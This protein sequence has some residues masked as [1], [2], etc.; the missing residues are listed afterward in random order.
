MRV[1]RMPYLGIPRRQP[2]NGLRDGR[3]FVCPVVA[4]AGED[5]HYGRVEP[6]IGSSPLGA[7]DSCGASRRIFAEC[8]SS[9]GP[10]AKADSDRPR[11]CR[12]AAE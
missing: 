6:S 4:S 7:R 2:G 3:I 9:F 5:L 10:A 1:A 11:L 8:L 12:G